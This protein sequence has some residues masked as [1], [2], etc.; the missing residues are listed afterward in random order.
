MSDKGHE[1]DPNGGTAEKKPRRTKPRKV[2]G[3]IEGMEPATNPTKN[4]RVHK[5]AL[6]YVGSR[7]ERMA[8]TTEEVKAKNNLLDAMAD[9]GLERY[10]YG[11]LLVVVNAKKLIK[12]KIG[13]P[14]DEP[15]EEDE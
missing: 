3:H 2:Q 14:G 12:V 11:D 5:L 7:D 1:D 8:L 13:D 6:A 10:Q 4:P 9:E 15:E